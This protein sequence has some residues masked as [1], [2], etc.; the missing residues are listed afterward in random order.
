[1][2]PLKSHNSL[3]TES[4]DTE[5]IEMLDKEFKSL[6]LKVINGG[7]NDPNNVCTYE[8]MN[9]EKNDQRPQK[10]FKELNK[11]RM[12]FKE[13]DEKVTW[14][15]DSARKLISLKKVGNGKLNKSI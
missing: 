15:R 9:K 13:L 2:I 5:L 14:M 1:M 6:A 7:R 11:M 12:S 10:G 8:Y 4:K 3:I